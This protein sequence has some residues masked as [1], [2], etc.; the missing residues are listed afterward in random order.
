MVTKPECRNI[1]T[2][3]LDYYD[4]KPETIVKV[5]VKP[6]L[7]MNKHEPVLVRSYESEIFRSYF[8]LNVHKRRINF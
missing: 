4:P 1:R 8:R 2:F 3:S 6:S 5:S 7:K